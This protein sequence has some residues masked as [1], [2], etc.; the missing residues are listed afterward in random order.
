MNLHES[1]IIMQ[2]RTT[3]TIDEELL[4]RARQLTGI[5]ETTALVRAGL[6]ALI[7][8]ETG[9]APGR[10][11]RRGAQGALH[12]Q[13]ATELWA[14]ILVDTSVW[15]DHFRVGNPLL[16]EVLGSALVVTHPYVIGE[17]ACAYL[18]NRVRIPAIRLLTISP[19][20]PSVLYLRK[21]PGQNF[22]LDNLLFTW[23]NIGCLT[24]GRV[25]VNFVLV[26]QRAM[27]VV[28]ALSG[29]PGAQD[30]P[31]EG[32]QG[33]EDTPD[34][35]QNGGISKQVV[36]HKTLECSYDFEA[37]PDMLGTHSLPRN[38]ARKRCVRSR[39]TDEKETPE[40]PNRAI[41]Y[42]G[43]SKLTQKTNPKQTQ[44][45]ATKSFV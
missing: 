29:C 44:N 8:Q 30:L 22:I 7:A 24:L 18:Q 17:L 41:M 10:S 31:Y 37:M 19:Q 14:M 20:D 2:M 35:T 5:E 34:D 3:L 9:E 39:I 4:D 23:Y 28:T 13:A 15:I 43:I 21:L 38:G 45:K 42:H 6:T 33:R 25:A 27:V 16:N 11:W 12:S 26:S 40:R 32:C 1:C 36:E